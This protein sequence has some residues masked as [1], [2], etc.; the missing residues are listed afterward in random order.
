[1]DARLHA[2]LSKNMY[3][4]QGFD[5]LIGP[6]CGQ[7]CHS[8][9]VV[10]YCIPGSAQRQ[11]AYAIFSQSLRASTVLKTLPLERPINSQSPFSSNTLKNL[12][13]IRTELLEF[14]PATVR[15]ASPS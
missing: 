9:I 2:V 14:C 13:G 12:F 11:A 1:M 3:S 15:Y 8:L 7:V 4:L 6:D 10:S 5:A